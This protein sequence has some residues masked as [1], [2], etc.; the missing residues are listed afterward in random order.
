MCKKL[1]HNLRQ[2]EME[3]WYLNLFNPDQNGRLLHPTFSNSFSC[4]NCICFEW[5]ITG[6]KPLREPKMTKSNYENICRCLNMHEGNS[7]TDCGLW[8]R[9]NIVFGN[10]LLPDGTKKLSE[11][12]FSLEKACVI[13]LR[14]ISQW[15]PK[16]LF[17]LITLKIISLK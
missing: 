10:G 11:T 8:W 4:N 3:W 9:V 13:H 16:L 1:F 15:V 7:V 12:T 14:A 17:W 2:Q 5:D 6:D